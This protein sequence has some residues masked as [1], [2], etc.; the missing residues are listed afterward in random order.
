MLFEQVRIHNLFS[1]YGEQVFDLALPGDGRN[2]ALIGGRNGFGKTSFIN[3]LKLLFLGPHENLRAAVQVGRGLSPSNYLLGMGDEWLGIFN[4]QAR[5][6]GKTEFG[7]TIIW[8]EPEGRVKAQRLWRLD[9]RGGY[10][11]TLKIVPN[12]TEPPT[13]LE[14]AEDFLERRLPKNFVSFF[15]YDGEQVQR[16]AEA[17][18]EGQL[19]Q[20]EKI[21]DIA[22]IE[23][24]IEYIGKN[25]N[26]WRRE[27]SESSPET[28]LT[29]LE[30]DL[31]VLQAEQEGVIQKIDELKEEIT[32]LDR[33]INRNRR[34]LEHHRAFVHQRDE[35]VYKA[36]EQRIL[37]QLETACVELANR[38]PIDAP[39]L[40]NPQLVIKATTDLRRLTE[41]QA[42]GLAQEVQTLLNALPARLL[43]EPPHFQPPLSDQQREFY[44][45]KLIRI[46]RS[47]ET[48][49]EDMSNGLM[50][51]EPS[52]AARLVE[53]L[54]YYRLADAERQRA[55]DD[56]HRISQLKRDLDDTRRKLDDMSSLSEEEQ[57]AY[58]QRQ[59]QNA[60]LEQQRDTLRGQLNDLQ[61]GFQEKNKAIENKK[62]EIKQQELAIRLDQERQVRVDL[63]S[64]LQRIFRSYKQQLKSRRRDDIEVAI[65]HRFKEL[66]TSHHQLAYIRV[67]ESFDL[68]YLNAANESV[69]MANMA[70][71]MKQLIATALLWALKDVSGRLV[72][73]VIDTPLARIDREHQINLL[74][75]YYPNASDQVIVLPTDSE[76]DAEKY[77]I[78]KPY[79]YREYRLGNTSGE[80]TIPLHEPLFAAKVG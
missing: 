54:N 32:N 16:L 80:H 70:A 76:L 67:G 2:V 5:R 48:D 65:N 13:D 4:R 60:D 58:Q 46:L 22:D 57:R 68:H 52:L 7:I 51:L 63:G 25:V 40:F 73:V 64:T 37:E 21:L 27:R 29:V 39:L 30:R 15:F 45:K 20:I 26:A 12:F 24:L 53:R 38:L 69:G 62:R 31:A 75:R 59:A 36:D 43:D 11:E 50:R 19:A 72:P 14:D 1:Y 66:M 56:L 74:T 55:A 49:P 23:I 18:R 33:D 34:Y 28:L 61:K 77:Q 3:S 41:S 35:A 6:E 79:V 44:R 8:Q 47:Y 71:G 10:E 17:N 9:R 78:L 42:S